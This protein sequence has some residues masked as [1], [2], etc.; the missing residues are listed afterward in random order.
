MRSTSGITCCHFFCSAVFSIPVCRKP[1]VASAL[2]ITSPESCTTRFRTPCVLGCCGPMLT[3]IVSLRSSGMLRLSKDR[4]Q[5]KE[6]GREPVFL[7]LFCLLSSDFRLSQTVLFY[8]FTDDMYKGPVDLLHPRGVL[9]GHVHVNVGRAAHAAAVP[10]GQRD[11]LQ[12]PRLRDLQRQHHVRRLAAGGNPERD[13]PGLAQRFDLPRE[14]LL[15]RVVVRDALDD[16][17]VGR[18][19]DGRQGRALALKSSD[20]LRRHWLRF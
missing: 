11:R 4:T 15:E 8:D 9:V 18:Q 16:A 1:M 7:A 5:K 17:R 2:T 6:D 20:Q 3:V 12:A 10:A 19:G 14:H 13:V